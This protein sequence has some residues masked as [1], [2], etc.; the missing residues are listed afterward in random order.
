MEQFFT[1]PAQ[2]KQKPT[3]IK[4]E[5]VTGT[6]FTIKFKQVGPQD[7]ATGYDIEILNTA[8][9]KKV[10]KKDKHNNLGVPIRSVEVTDLKPKTEYKVRI[11]VTNRVGAGL[12]SE[13]VTTTTAGRIINTSRQKKKYFMN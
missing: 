11:R 13:Y 3:D 9:N 7:L 5:E 4:I 6:S 2:P 12:W 8:T 1:F 10:E